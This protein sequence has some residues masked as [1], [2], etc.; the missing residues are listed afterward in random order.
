VN[1]NEWL[2]GILIFQ[3]TF[4]ISKIYHLIH[5]MFKD[6]ISTIVKELQN[7]QTQEHINEVIEP[8]SYR[9]KSAFYIVVLLL[10]LMVG[11]LVYSNILLSEI[12]KANRKP[13]F[14][15]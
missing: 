12:V 15:S 11:N 7:E 1:N 4:Y 2:L 10:I 8:I 3:S 6:I 5:K 13:V 14:A 9:M